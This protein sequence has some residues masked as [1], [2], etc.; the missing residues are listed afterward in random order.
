[1]R[2]VL[3]KDGKGPSGSLHIGEVPIPVIGNR[4]VLVKIK[5]FGLNRMD[6]SQ[7]EGK[8]PPPPGS[9]TILGVEFSGTI[10]SISPDVRNWQVG[11]E[12]L[13]LAG[14]GAYAEFIAVKQTHIIRKPNYLSWVDAASI[15][16]VFLTAFQALVVIGQ[17]GSNDNVLVHAAASGVGIAAIQLAR[18]YGAHKVIGT[19]STQTK[20]D[21]L[22]KLPNGPTDAINYKTQDFA[23]VS[24]QITGNKGVNVVIDFVGKTHFNK[25]IDVLAVDGRMTMLSLLSGTTVE[26]VNLMPILYKRLH[27]EGST[28]RSRSVEY[29]ANLISRFRDEVF[30]KIT[31]EA[32]PGPI[33]TF[34]HKV[35]SWND[36]RLAHEEMEANN[37]S[38]KIVVEVD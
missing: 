33:R 22:L 18:I 12:V 37:N 21:W 1:M 23:L 3:V 27:I 29:Q 24:K 17:V 2:A 19:T 5:A 16:E 6:I 9:S 14:G 15:P 11:D 25:N 8:Y 7:R 26:E 32:G 35:Y 30:A 4:E 31:G 20:I 10:E 38:G 34:I 28:L 36:I 13:G